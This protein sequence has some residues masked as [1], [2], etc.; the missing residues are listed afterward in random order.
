MPSEPRIIDRCAKVGTGSLERLVDQDLP[1]RV[2]EVVV[3]ADDVGDEHVDV[4]DDLAK[5]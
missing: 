4:V 3:A 2:R 5:L 1:R